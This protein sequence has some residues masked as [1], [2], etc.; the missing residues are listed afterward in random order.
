MAG[1]DQRRGVFRFT[2]RTVTDAARRARRD[3]GEDTAL[4]DV[5]TVQEDSGE[6]KTEIVVAVM[7]RIGIPSLVEFIN[8]PADGSTAASPAAGQELWPPRFQRI[9][10]G[11]LRTGVTRE[12]ATMLVREAVES[13]SGLESMPWE[14]L[15]EVITR[16]APC[17]SPL[18]LSARQVFGLAGHRDSGRTTVAQEICR[19]AGAV[20]P[21]RI[22][23][24]TADDAVVPEAGFDVSYIMEP[25]EAAHAVSF[26]EDLRIVLLDLPPIHDRQRNLG[27]SGWMEA[28]PDLMLIPVVTQDQ[29]LSNALAT[30]RQCAELRSTGWIM[31]RQD[32][33]ATLGLLLNLA[34]A[35][36]GP[37]GIQ[38]CTTDSAAPHLQLAHWKAVFERLRGQLGEEA[39]TVHP[40]D[41]G[42]G[43][44]DA[45]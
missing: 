18:D 31:S 2:G 30:V 40:R 21:D 27:F 17:R 39:E 35:G 7:D 15:E 8:R 1:N 24:V 6:E 11:L 3:L 32:H 25:A 28:F 16:L 10:D 23:L 44:E 43:G 38:G 36:G 19:M 4:L 42:G 20:V 33:D 26:N 13:D 9:M 12:Q 22:L 37:L 14:T 45:R 29:S 41:G 34:L 5:R